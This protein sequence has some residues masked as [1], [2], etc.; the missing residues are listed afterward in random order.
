[1][2]KLNVHPFTSVNDGSSQFTPPPLAHYAMMFGMWSG[3]IEYELR[4]IMTDFHKVRVYV[5]WAPWSSTVYADIN[6]MSITTAQA[7]T[8][9][10]LVEFTKNSTFR[11]TVGWGDSHA[12]HPLGFDGNNVHTFY[13][14]LPYV[15]FDSAAFYEPNGVLFIKVVDILKVQ[16][17]A[18][19][20]DVFVYA[21]GSPNLYFKGPTTRFINSFVPVSLKG[22]MA[23]C[24][25]PPSVFDSSA[26]MTPSKPC[27]LAG[28]VV[29]PS[30]LARYGGEV[31]TSAR[32]L[33]RKYMP[34]Y[35]LSPFGDE[36]IDSF[37]AVA[38]RFVCEVPIYNATVFNIDG[39]LSS[40]VFD[41]WW[42][43]NFVSWMSS[44]FGATSGSLRYKIF[45]DDNS[46]NPS[47]RCLTLT[48]TDPDCAMQT[49][50]GYTV[51]TNDS[52]SPAS[53]ISSEAAIPS[54]GTFSSTERVYGD[55]PLEVEVPYDEYLRFYTVE[56][57]ALPT[58]KHFIGQYMTYSGRS[59]K[60][61]SIGVQVFTA[62]GEDFTAYHYMGPGI[63]EPR[64]IPYPVFQ[65]VYP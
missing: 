18:A 31:I 45:V 10:V 29:P 3:S 21:R 30:L 35:W 50:T 27:L 38:P 65:S 55:D 48:R 25:I 52:S 62:I 15:N 64:S 4:P 5:G 6:A 47:A 41:Q 8:E 57:N 28:R 16:N 20:V 17:S 39:S 33:M 1:V 24:Q 26:F 44:A 37:S 42:Y 22:S 32:L 46:T 51:F 9:G 53:F 40:N 14:I 54:A 61:M 49:T 2:L 34:A 58:A 12:F 23:N 43:G 60:P 11:F 59:V 63:I 56:D 13:N 36:T 19:L 7:E